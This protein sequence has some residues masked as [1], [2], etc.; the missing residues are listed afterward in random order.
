MQSKKRGVLP[1]GNNP[2]NQN[3]A[4]WFCV[5]PGPTPFLA[6]GTPARFRVAFLRPLRR[7][8][9]RL[10]TISRPWLRPQSQE[11]LTSLRRVPA[12]TPA[13]RCNSVLPA[14]FRSEDY[15]CSCSAFFFAAKTS[16]LPT[17]RSMLNATLSK[18]ARPTVR[19]AN[20]QTH[21]PGATSSNGKRL[22]ATAA[23]TRFPAAGPPACYRE[24]LR[25][26]QR[27]LCA[28]MCDVRGAER[29]CGRRYVVL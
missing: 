29:G 18:E 28:T 25:L 13:T 23:R 15:P 2:E 9:G 1:K 27:M 3:L 16:P 12:R 4:V 24:P 14:D 17:P 22:A 11:P 10:R 26:S 5:R 21:T 8:I 20:G 19:C 7:E 6:F